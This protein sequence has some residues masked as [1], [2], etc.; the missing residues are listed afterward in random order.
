MLSPAGVVHLFQKLAEPDDCP[1]YRSAPDLLQVVTRGDAHGI[2][3]AVE[4]LQH[5][6]DLD[7]RTNPAGGAMF[8]MDRGA[9]RD[10][11]AF[12]IRLE[13]MKRC[14]LHQP[15]HVR[16][17]VNRWQLPMMRGQRVLE[18]NGLDRLTPGAERN[19][20]RQSILQKKV[21]QRFYRS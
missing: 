8:D 19:L 15:D 13:R 1:S 4:S 21:N 9:Y 11:V 5:C 20:L 7:V 3:T 10:L 18:F 12:A 16:R 6:F 17:G 14:R 2:E